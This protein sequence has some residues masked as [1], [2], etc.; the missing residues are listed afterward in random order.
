MRM[1]S[2]LCTYHE[3]SIAD[4]M[5]NKSTAKYDYAAV[6]G[7]DRLR[8]DLPQICYTHTTL[9]V[10]HIYI[11]KYSRFTTFNPNCRRKCCHRLPTKSG[12]TYMAADL[13]YF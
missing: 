12:P 7:T 2:V 3:I 10:S 9:S 13:S 6:L 8:V 4:V 11:V 5:L 1:T